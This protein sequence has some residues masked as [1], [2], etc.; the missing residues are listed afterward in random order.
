MILGHS[1]L[2][3]THT[4]DVCKGKHPKPIKSKDHGK[5]AFREQETETQTVEKEFLI[6][7]QLIFNVL[8]G[9]AVVAMLAANIIINRKRTHYNA[10]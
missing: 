1:C 9:F 2:G 10:I 5:V 8:I 4:R 7:G 3:L 6:S